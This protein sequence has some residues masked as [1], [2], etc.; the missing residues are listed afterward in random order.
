MDHCSLN[1][2]LN[3]IPVHSLKEKLYLECFDHENRGK[4]R[5]LG[6]TELEV[7]DLIKESDDGNISPA[8]L[9]DK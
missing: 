6:F 2:K 9:I 5:T 1:I 8:E 7:K 4:D 3:Y